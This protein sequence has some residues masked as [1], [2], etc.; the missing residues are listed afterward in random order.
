MELP[1][2]K[3]SGWKPTS[4]IRRNSFTDRSEVNIAL[5]AGTVLELG[6]PARG[7]GG[8]PLMG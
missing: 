3:P 5:V 6:Q 7:V 4:L 2:T 8:H 1:I